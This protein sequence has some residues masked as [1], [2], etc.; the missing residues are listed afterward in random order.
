[1][2]DS[3]ELEIKI[4]F[5]TIHLEKEESFT[6]QLEIFEN[7][8]MYELYFYKKGFA[9]I[10]EMIHEQVYLNLNEYPIKDAEASLDW[11]NGTS[12]TKQ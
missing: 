4:C 3:L 8:D 2:N 7:N 12:T 10:G 6:E 1:M 9:D 5:L 11:A